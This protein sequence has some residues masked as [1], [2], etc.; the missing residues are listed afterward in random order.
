M[1]NPYS[2]EIFVPD[3]N[4]NGLKVISQRN[5]TGVVLEFPREEWK[6]TRA[7]NEF[8]QTG[9]YI[10]MGY[11]D[12]DGDLPVLYIGQTDELRKRIDQ[13]DKSKDFWDRCVVFVS[14]NNF[15]NRAHVTWLEW[16]LYA[17]AAQLNRCKLDN[18][19]VPQQPSLSPQ[20]KAEMEV[21]KNQIYQVLP[22]IGVHSFE[23]GRSIKPALTSSISLINHK[24]DD[25]LIVPA[26]K[27]GF[28]A[29]FIGMNCWYAIRIAGGKL[30][31]IKYIAAYQ[32][33]PTTAI[34]H[35]AEVDSIEPY[36]N[37]GKYKVNFKAPAKEIKHVPFGDA[38]S[39]S[40]QGTRYSSYDKLIGANQLSDLF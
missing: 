13:H 8:S 40:M 27:E 3:G 21:F 28:D 22:L 2:I 15:L 17:Q 39:G 19:Q 25:L 16:A 36:G 14:S 10:L 23:E 11:Y 35:V 26:K 33:A 1:G 5:W 9:L 30:N 31:Q 32:S 37:T 12:D 4:S 18:N 38:K 34:T 29:V 24:K 6:E 7:R 20:E